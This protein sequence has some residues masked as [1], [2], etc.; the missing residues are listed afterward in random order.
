MEVEGA[1]PLITFLNRIDTRMDCLEV[2]PS[3]EA[4]AVVVAVELTVIQ[5]EQAEL[6]AMMLLNKEAEEHLAKMALTE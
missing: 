5:G 4:V 1:V 6:Q 3:M 2:D